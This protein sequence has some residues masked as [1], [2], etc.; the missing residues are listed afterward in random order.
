MAG[1]TVSVDSEQLLQLA[2]S[3][4]V[5]ATELL[6]RQGAEEGASATDLQLLQADLIAT[7]DALAGA[8]ASDNADGW[9]DLEQAAGLSSEIGVVPTTAPLQP[10]ARVRVCEVL[11][12]PTMPLY[13][14]TCLAVI[15]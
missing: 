15:I 2:L 9:E 3:D 13:L 8:R 12:R 6:H 7:L 5:L 10:T 4:C 1:Q 11:F 14:D